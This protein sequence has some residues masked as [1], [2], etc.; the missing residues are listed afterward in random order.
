M[1]KI[2]LF[3]MDGTITPP[4]K[5]IEKEMVSELWLL[6]KHYDI[7]IVTG[8]DFEYL[9]QQC[10]DLFK[11]IYPLYWSIFPCNG[12][13][14]YDVTPESTA[15]N[16]VWEKVYEVD[17]KKAMGDDT[18]N[19]LVSELLN[20][21]S[22]IVDNFTS[23]TSDK[24][25]DIT[26]TFFQYRGSML[27]WCPIGRSAGTEERSNWVEADNRFSIREQFK[28]K[29]LQDP[30]FSCLDVALGGETSFD[31]YPKGWDK[32][33][34]MR[35]LSDYNEVYFVGDACHP[36][37]NDYTLYNLLGERAFHTSGPEQTLEI[38]EKL[39]ES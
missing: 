17:M 39:I 32:T 23:P 9:H 8:S 1:N 15:S 3:D 7:G 33:Y 20:F 21:Q 29:I 18:Y 12:T 4:R 31:I 30:R 37:G 24:I 11:V 14:K 16:K 19:E 34:V 10:E 22:E 26:G 38:I 2:V 6:D 35:H 28:S 5:P 27:N 36:G 13:K 25:I